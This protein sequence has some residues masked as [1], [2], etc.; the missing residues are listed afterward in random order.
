M[1]SGD[2]LY[3][4]KSIFIHLFAFL[5]MLFYPFSS[6]LLWIH[7]KLLKDSYKYM[8]KTLHNSYRKQKALLIH[9][10]IP[11][12]ANKGKRFHSAG[13]KLALEEVEG[14]QPLYENS[15]S[16]LPS[17]N[18]CCFLFKRKEASHPTQTHLL[19]STWASTI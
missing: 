7:T 8:W 1:C 9:V 3:F 13:I 2:H 14:T 17:C 5:F 11:R 19:F 16:C 4:R 18:L 12:K 6:Q 15:S 10:F